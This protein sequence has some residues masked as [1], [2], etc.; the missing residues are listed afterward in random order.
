MKHLLG[1]EGLSKD[2]F[3]ALIHNASNMLEISSREVK[4]VPALRGKTV[5]NLFLEPSTR[6][7]ASFEIAAKRLS[8]LKTAAQ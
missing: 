8:A 1:I 4:K 2:E 7:R 5:V 3:L 6:T